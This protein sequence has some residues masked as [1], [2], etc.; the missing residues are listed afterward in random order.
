MEVLRKLS[1]DVVGIGSEIFFVDEENV[2]IFPIPGKKIG[3]T[4]DLHGY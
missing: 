3:F 4:F 2:S 1:R